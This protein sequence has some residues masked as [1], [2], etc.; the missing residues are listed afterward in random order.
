MASKNQFQP[1]DTEAWARRTAARLRLIHASF[2]DQGFDQKRTY[3]EDEIE[4]ALDDAGA[5]MEDQR[6]G[7]LERLANCFPLGGDVEGGRGRVGSPATGA[8]AEATDGAEE[9]LQALIGF[10]RSGDA[11]QRARITQ[12]LVAAGIVPD[13]QVAGGVPMEISSRV[14]LPHRADSYMEFNRGLDQLWKELGIPERDAGRVADFNRLFKLLGI[15][16]SAQRVLHKFLWEF[17]RDTV[18]LNLQSAWVSG[19]SEPLEKSIAAYLA[20][21]EGVRSIDI[22]TEVEKTKNL[23]LAVCVAARKG[24][25]EFARSQHRHLAPDNIEY[26]VQAEETAMESSRVKDLGRKAWNKYRQL[27]KHMTP[28]AINYEFHRVF[29]GVMIAWLRKR[30]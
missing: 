11:E 10:W 22:A 3:I 16:I 18:P 19:I 9:P 13:A 26:A 2:S 8:R 28:D 6:H 7:M 25:E 30:G 21:E 24:A 1:S 20:G 12:A 29:S 15:L 27:S 5:V 23:I 4:F 14:K 17:W